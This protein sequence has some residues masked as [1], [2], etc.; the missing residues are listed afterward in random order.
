MVCLRACGFLKTL[1]PSWGGTDLTAPAD[2]ATPTDPQNARVAGLLLGT[3]L[4][5]VSGGPIAYVPTTTTADQPATE[6]E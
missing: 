5:S 6:R 2:A 3:R 4:P 1:D